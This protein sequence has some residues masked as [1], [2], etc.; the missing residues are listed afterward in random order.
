[1]LGR[2]SSN[3][4]VIKTDDLAAFVAAEPAFDAIRSAHPN[5][6]ISLLTTP[7]LQR[8]A[9][10]APYFD[11]VAGLPD[12]GNP[13]ERKAFIKQLKSSKFEIVY[14]LA[15]NDDGKK[16]HAAMG[17]FRPKWHVA[18]AP[19]KRARRKSAVVSEFPNVEKLLSGAGIDAPHRLPSF[20]WALDARKDS[21]N[22]RPSWYGIS[23]PFGL[24]LPS[25]DETKR[26][27]AR[28]YASLASLMAA[29]G[30]MP[31][32]AGHKDLHH[33]GDEIAHDAPQLVDLTGKTDHLQLAALAR[34]ASFFVSDDA[35]EFHLAMSV[36]CQ[37]VLIAAAKNAPAPPEGRHVIVLTANEDLGE[38]EADFVWQRLGNMGLI[39]DG[40]PAKRHAAAR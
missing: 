4:L 8:I 14:D 23:G 28:G 2:K 21:A 32:L 40:A 24:L 3:I 11:Q 5:A 13:V 30:F 7:A 26:W 16:L 25:L 12:F 6:Q 34:E 19:K 38:I 15:G 18:D 37:G 35:A 39:D 17:P 20:S 22:M 31:V 1:M 9:R 27:N 36:G 10:A 33:F 29:N